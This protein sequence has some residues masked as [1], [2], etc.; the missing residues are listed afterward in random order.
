MS[1]ENWTGS[2]ETFF[3]FFAFCQDDLF[4]TGFGLFSCLIFSSCSGWFLLW[5]CWWPSLTWL[6]LMQWLSYRGWALR[7]LCCCHGRRRIVSWWVC[8][9][10]VSSWSCVL[11]DQKKSLGL[12]CHLSLTWRIPELGGDL[13]NL[14]VSL[15]IIHIGKTLPYLIFDSLKE[16]WSSPRKEPD[17]H[18]VVV[19]RMWQA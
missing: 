15:L 8:L 17:L 16:M 14:S 4:K 2:Y 10:G 11:C 13:Q 7:H 3:F 12:S 9:C 18:S 19:L 5:S 1:C 6:W